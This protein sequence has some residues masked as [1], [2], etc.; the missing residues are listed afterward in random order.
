MAQLRAAQLPGTRPVLPAQCAYR[1]ESQRPRQMRSALPDAEARSFSSTRTDAVLPTSVIARGSPGH[2]LPSAG[3]T[4]CERGDSSMWSSLRRA[5]ARE[6]RCG[7]GCTPSA[8]RPW[9][10]SGT[11]VAE[12]SLGRDFR[13]LR[14][15]TP[16]PPPQPRGDPPVNGHYTWCI[17]CGAVRQAAPMA[18]G[19]RCATCGTATRR[20]AGSVERWRQPRRFRGCRHSRG[21]TQGAVGDGSAA[22]DLLPERPRDGLRRHRPSGPTDSTARTPPPRA[23]IASPPATAQ[24]SAG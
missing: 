12:A 7:G 2:P 10:R 15:E 23:R 19:E 1:H 16:P 11:Y 4:Q 6:P 9:A 20:S 24:T 5:A 3:A 22:R 17:P 8:G 14:G 18:D 13:G 21:R